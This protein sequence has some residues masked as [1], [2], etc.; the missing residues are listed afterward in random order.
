MKKK[1][2]GNVLYIAKSGRDNKKKKRKRLKIFNL[3]ML[4]LATYFVFT[5]ARQEIELRNIK[6]ETRAANK[7]YEELKQ[8]EGI[9]NKKIT[10]ASS[11]HIVENKAK[12]ILGWVSEGEY[13][14]IE[15]K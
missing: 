11:T 13:K 1:N 7:E 3:L 10:D 5:I 14:V 4:F 9:I 12:S 8:Q 6:A 15:Q 2:N